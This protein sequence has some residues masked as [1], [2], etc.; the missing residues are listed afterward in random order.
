MDVPKAA[1]ACS[2][3]GREFLPGEIFFSALVEERTALRRLDFAPENWTPPQNELPINWVA[4]WKTRIPETQEKKAKL[5]PNDILLE[6]FG[7]L[8]LQGDEPDTLYVLTL[9]LIRR[10]LMRYEREE[11][12]QAGQKILVVYGLKDNTAYEVP[13]A[14]PDRERLE[15]VQQ[16]LAQLLYC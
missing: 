10:R 5:A 4:W 12:N 1:K 13:M 2:V 11:K 15:E 14:M 7:K 16:Q 6:L 8:L 3:S 9:L